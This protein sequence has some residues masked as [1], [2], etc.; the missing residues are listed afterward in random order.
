MAARASD[1]RL[2][3]GHQDPTASPAWTFPTPQKAGDDG[4]CARA[5]LCE[6]QLQQALGKSELADV[7]FHINGTW[8]A[9]GHRSVLSARSAVFGGM[10]TNETEERRSGVIRL[11]DVTAAGLLAFLEFLY[12]GR[13]SASLHISY[14][15]FQISVEQAGM[16]LRSAWTKI[17]LC[18][19]CVCLCS[20]PPSLT[21]SLNFS[22][23][24]S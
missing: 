23:T 2:P 1:T 12:L 7:Q 14:L 15:S 24:H 9:S 18:A 21:H 4:A 5:S 10:F 20:L 22:H 13:I 3:T 8:L 6:E 16:K 19:V 17:M 11:D